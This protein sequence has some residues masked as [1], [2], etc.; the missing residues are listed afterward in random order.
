MCI[1]SELELELELR[2]YDIESI[3]RIENG[4]FSL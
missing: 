4:S 2:K 3:E 1:V